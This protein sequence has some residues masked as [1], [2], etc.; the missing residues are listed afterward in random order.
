MKRNQTLKKR[1][2]RKNSANNKTWSKNNK[3]MKQNKLTR[4][5]LNEIKKWSNEDLFV[6]LLIKLSSV[7]L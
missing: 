3:I 4:K 2:N 7:K 5:M 1:V 6:Y